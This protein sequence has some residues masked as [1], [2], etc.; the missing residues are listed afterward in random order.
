MKKLHIITEAVF[1]IGPN[2]II[3]SPDLHNKNHWIPYLSFFDELIIVARV[4]NVKKNG[5]LI[6]SVNH[7]R[8]KFLPLPPYRGLIEGL[9]KI[10]ALM[11]LMWCESKFCNVSLLRLPG[12]ISSFWGLMVLFRN[13]PYA[14]QIVGDGRQALRGPGFNIMHRFFGYIN[15]IILRYICKKSSVSRY[16]TQEY[17]QNIYPPGIKTKIFSISDVELE[18]REPVENRKKI[19]SRF[20]SNVYTLSFCGSLAQMYKGLDVLIK[21]VSMLKVNGTIVVVNVAGDGIYRDYFEK[22]AKSYSVSDLFRFHGFLNN[23][24]VVDMYDH[25]DIFV[26]PSRTEGLPRAMIEAMARGLPCIGS[27]V[28]GIP[29]LLRVEALV[30]ADNVV[31]LCEKIL[32]FLNNKEFLKFHAFVNYQKSKEY[33]PDIANK[34]RNDFL[35]TLKNLTQ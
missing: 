9:I 7:C 10:P 21:S 2:H 5:S 27:N 3:W 24:E 25:S 26:M 35:L 31:K 28:G 16:V 30:P 34:K 29:E 8:I 33:E 4:N 14:C 13:K 15:D 32:E 17:L 1:N 22:L 12:P 6:Q 19:N 11:W 23:N 18:W 20:S